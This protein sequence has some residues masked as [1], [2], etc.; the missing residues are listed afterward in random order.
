MHIKSNL[1]QPAMAAG[2]E[3][4]LT[5][6]IDWLR[7]KISELSL[8]EIPAG[9]NVLFQLLVWLAGFGIIFSR[10]PDA[11]LNSQFWAEDGPRW[12]ADAYQFGWHCLLIPDELGGYFH[13]ASRLAGLT[14]LAVPLAFAPLVM[15]LVAIAIQILPASVFLSSRFSNISLLKRALAAFVYFALPNSYEVNANATT[16]QWHLGLLAVMLLLAPSTRDWRWHVFDGIILV[17]TA[18]DS[19]VGVVLLPVAMVVW[20][21]RRSRASAISLACLVPAALIQALTVLFSHA[22]PAAPN[23][24]NW[25]RLV[26]ILGGQVFL[27]PLLGNTTLVHMAWRHFPD[28]IFARE[29][30]AFVVGIAILIYVLRYAPAEVKL[31]ILFGFTILAMSLAR[32]IP[33]L[34]P[35]PQW[36][37]MSF[38]GHG[39]RYYILPSISF[40][41]GLAWIATSAPKIPRWIATALLLLL[42]IGIKRDWRYPDFKDLHFKEYAAKFEAA[43]PGTKIAIPL[44]P[45]NDAHW[46]LELTKH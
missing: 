18:L 33:G 22:R 32:P 28:Y 12:Y 10:R 35:Q 42:P 36:E 37:L 4:A 27:S 17:L 41:V 14:S 24:A 46:T 44:N 26:S 16:I 25:H 1:S 21:L 19:P 5:K 20:W 34:A 9:Y 3:P 8:W 39:N 23:G 43:P 15:N 40:L 7:A 45:V 2:N 38:P 29:T 31:F 13:S 30:F 11:I 6:R